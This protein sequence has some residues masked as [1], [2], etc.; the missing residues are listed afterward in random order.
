MVD[1]IFQIAF[2]VQRKN[3]FGRKTIGNYG[4]FDI[5]VFCVMGAVYTIDSTVQQQQNTV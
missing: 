5:I 3:N 2:I 4:K 1:R